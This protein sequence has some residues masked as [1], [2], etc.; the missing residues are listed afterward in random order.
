M[1]LMRMD[2]FDF[3]TDF[4]DDLFDFEDFEDDEDDEDGEGDELALG[5]ILGAGL[6]AGAGGAAG[7]GLYD[8]G[9]WAFGKYAPQSLKSANRR[10]VSKYRNAP[11]YARSFLGNAGAGIGGVVG[12]LLGG[13][14]PTPEADPYEPEYE[15]D[16]VDEMEALME[17]ALEGDGEDA[18]D[19]IDAMVS[20]AFGP[21]RAAAAIRRVM[22]TIRSRIRR[23][24]AMARRDP[25]Y[26]AAAR[27]AP[28]ALRRT[29]VALLQMYSRGKRVDA[30]V[31][32]RVFAGVM[33]QILRHPKA[34]RT[35]LGRNRARV[36]RTRVQPR[37][38]RRATPRR[39]N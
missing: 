2:D 4:E 5:A 39:A 31:A 35:A 17:I 13:A 32:L 14:S 10:L 30:Q 21:M 26:R 29:A 23:L 24:V 6:G 36:R 8:L 7:T 27:V 16:A 20:L 1:T 25:R 28:V 11:E 19:A 22:A 18:G 9:N 3:E 38:P 15:S 33:A 12:G 37:R 34:R